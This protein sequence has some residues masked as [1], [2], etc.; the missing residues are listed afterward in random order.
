MKPA[1]RYNVYLKR[2]LNETLILKNETIKTVIYWVRVME[3]PLSHLKFEEV[4]R[5]NNFFY[6]TSLHLN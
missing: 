4:E 1:T 2:G 6:L 3:Y 5:A